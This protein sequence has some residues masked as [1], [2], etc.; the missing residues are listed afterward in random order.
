MSGMPAL[1]KKQEAIL[2]YL[3]EDPSSVRDANGFIAAPDIHAW[4]RFNKHGVVMDALSQLNNLGAIVN[5]ENTK[6]DR[7]KVAE[8][9]KEWPDQIRERDQPKAAAKVAKPR[10]KK[11]PAKSVPASSAPART[12]T[13]K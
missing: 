5:P 3:D 12:R 7:W 11:P 13:P 6:A 8:M 10:A 9:A 2:R 4:A 1:D